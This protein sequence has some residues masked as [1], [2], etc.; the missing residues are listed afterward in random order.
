MEATVQAN[1]V[2]APPQSGEPVGVRFFEMANDDGKQVYFIAIA[3]HG[4]NI[5]PHTDEGQERPSG[6]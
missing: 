5:E 1:V 2:D 6:S 3:P 4:G